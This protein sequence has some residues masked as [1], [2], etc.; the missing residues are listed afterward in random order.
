[1]INFYNKILNKLARVQGKNLIS[2]ISIPLSQYSIIVPTESWTSGANKRLLDVSLAAIQFAREV[3]HTDIAEKMIERPC[4]PVIWPGEHYRLLSGLIQV[5]QPKVVVEIGTATGYSALSIKKFLPQDSKLFSF[6]IVPW[7]QFPK[8][9]LKTSDFEDGKFEQIIADL[10]DP[11]D[12]NRHQEILSKADFVFIDAAKD[13]TQEQLFINNF[14]RLSFRNK[15]LFMFDD[16]RVMNMIDIWNKIDR[17][18]IDLTSFGHWSGT[19]LVDWLG[20]K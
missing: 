14:N 19:G 8:C 5:L 20:E 13:G 11:T 10:T 18:K 6:D 1:M 3:D 2:K 15:P 17:P 12:F 4:W 16:T 7:Q 9:I